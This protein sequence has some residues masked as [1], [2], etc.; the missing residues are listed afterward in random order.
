M[1]HYYN[2]MSA[3]TSPPADFEQFKTLLNKTSILYGETSV[4]GIGKRRY[5]NKTAKKGNHQL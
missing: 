2:F 5:N 1:P 3:P 4:A